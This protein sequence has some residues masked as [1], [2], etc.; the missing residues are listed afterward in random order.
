MNQVLGHDVGNALEVHEAVDFLTGAAPRPRLHAVTSA[1]AR[2]MLVLGGLARD[3][4]EAAGPV[5]RALD[6][7]PPPSGSRAWS[8][9]R[10]ATAISWSALIRTSPGRRSKLCVM[11]ALAGVVAPGGR[12]ADRS[13]GDRAPAAAAAGVGDTV[14]PA[15]G[16]G[17][18]RAWG[19][20]SA[21]TA[22]SDVSRAL[23]GRGREG[24]GGAS[25]PPW[26]SGTGRPGRSA[27][28]NATHR[29]RRVE[30]MT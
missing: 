12:P 16:L 29:R 8:R 6:P 10:R 28:C 19:I 14:D 30:A 25:P 9:P 23:H 22:P 11:P 17:D 24:R 7:A 4:G 13:R 26:W 5:E 1:L 27:P 20:P 21:P 2:E 15:V 3:H 18:S